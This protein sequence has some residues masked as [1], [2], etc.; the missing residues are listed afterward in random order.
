M[1]TPSTAARLAECGVAK[2]VI[3]K[4]KEI[5]TIV[6]PGSIGKKITLILEK[7]GKQSNQLP[8]DIELLQTL[9]PKPKRMALNQQC[10][11][12]NDLVAT[13][14]CSGCGTP[15]CSQECTTK[16]WKSHK[17]CRKGRRKSRVHRNINYPRCPHPDPT[18]SVLRWAGESIR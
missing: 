10:G 11:M 3:L 4:T 13:S 16:N 5:A 1:I 6:K 9:T 15:A 7:S 8:K 17:L 18:A 12:C 14:K 2:V